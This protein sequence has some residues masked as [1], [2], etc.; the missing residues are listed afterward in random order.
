MASRGVVWGTGPSSSSSCDINHAAS[1]QRKAR[2]IIQK[3]WECV[4]C[5]GC[6]ECI[7]PVKGVEG[8]DVRGVVC[9]KAEARH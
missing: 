4:S 9:G 5:E 8:E 6:D 7:V 2:D 1:M 3:N